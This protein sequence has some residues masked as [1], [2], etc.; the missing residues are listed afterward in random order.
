MQLKI[1]NCP[2]KDFK[3]YVER[4]ALFY[5]KQLI[6]DGRLR[7][8]CFTKIRFDAKIEEQGYCSVEGYNKRN[9]P[10]EFLIEIHPGLGAPTILEIL[11][12]EMVHV[13]Q[14]LKRQTD[15][16]LSSWM[17]KRVNYEKTDYWDQ[18]WEID[19]HGRESGLL[20]KFAE[21]EELWDVFHGFRKPSLPIVSEP[22]KWKR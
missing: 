17:G 19:A 14:F 4:A 1:V 6:P 5:A 18:P 8:R 9:E 21:K 13:K 10:R 16:N 3:P 2:D 7:N 15:E 11:A 12:H 20:T 22:I